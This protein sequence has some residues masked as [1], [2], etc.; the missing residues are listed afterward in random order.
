[1]YHSSAL[2][3][4]AEQSLVHPDFNT[5]P[6]EIHHDF[7]H[8]ASWSYTEHSTPYFASERAIPS[9]SETGQISAQPAHSRSTWRPAPAELLAQTRASSSI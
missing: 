2:K 4:D 9:T 1:M 7:N 5:L 3:F 6:K 8:Q